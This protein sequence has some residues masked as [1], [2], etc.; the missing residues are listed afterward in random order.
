MAKRAPGKAERRGLTIA[1]LIRL[2]P[3]DAAAE[4]WFSDTRWPDGPRCPRCESAN[5]QTGAA[6]ATMPMR[7]RDCRKRFSVKT[8]TAME[9]SNLGYQTWALA[10]YLLTTS[11]KSVSSM[12]LH[13]DLGISQKSAW[14]LAHRI[15]EA[16]ADDVDGQL[17][18]PAEVD[19][20][21]VGGREANKHEWHRE[22]NGPAEKVAV[23]GLKDRAT[24]TV[25]AKVVGQ[26]HGPVLRGFVREHAAPGAAVY[27]DGHPAYGPL[28]GEYDHRAVQHSAGTYVIEQTHTNGIES[29]WSMVRRGEHGTYHHWS[30]RHLQRYVDEFAGRHNARPLDTIDQM[31]AI[32]RGLVGKL[33]RFRELIA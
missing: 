3:D 24:G 33:L 18:R 1:E 20:A 27:S 32:A 30:P 6:H 31:R 7:C 10:T 28:D 19:E 9:A 5:V 4:R 29:F 13:R 21:F 22:Q 8:G 25:R 14:H 12:K 23:V 16:W 2:F 26:T 15:R 17:A 11:L